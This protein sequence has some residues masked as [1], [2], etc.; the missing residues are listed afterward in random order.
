MLAGF[1]CS[2]CGSNNASNGGDGGA[3]D[4]GQAANAITMGIGPIPLAAGEER[5]VCVTR[6]LGLTADIDVTQVVATLAPGSHHLVL[7]RSTE[8]VESL[9]PTDCQPFEGIQQGIVP[10]L[11]AEKASTTLTLPS[12]VAYHF[13]QDQM[14][15][16]EAHYINATMNAIQGQGTLVLTPGAT[17]VS[18][19]QADIMFCGSVRQLSQTGIPPNQTNVTLNPGFYKGGGDVDLTKLKVFAF[20]SH[21]HHLGSDVTVSKSTS[22]SDPGTL[23]YDNKSW[24]NPPLQAYD[25]AHLLTFGAGEGFRWQCSYD[26]ADAVP[27]PTTTTMFGTG[28]LDNEMCFIWAYYYPS[29]GRFVGPT[30]CAYQ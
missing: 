9:T 8:T 7:Y 25:D 13:P 27:K 18:Y 29:V 12:G 15:R 2:A 5:T 6:H 4:L 30:D 11:I 28:A 17:G 16:I 24:D 14:V 21:E 23:L 1:A 3:G 10:I 22:A 19:Q 26:S 20:T